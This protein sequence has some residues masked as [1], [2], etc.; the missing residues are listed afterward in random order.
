MKIFYRPDTIV[1]HLTQALFAKNLKVL[2]CLSISSCFIWTSVVI[3]VEPLHI[4]GIKLL[5][6][7]HHS[8]CQQVGFPNGDLVFK[9]LD[10]YRVKLITFKH[11]II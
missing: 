2:L 1:F 5:P 10:A 8:D 9:I 11:V 7:K 4:W 6:G 3:I